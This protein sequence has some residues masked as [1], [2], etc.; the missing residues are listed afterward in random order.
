MESTIQNIKDLENEIGRLKAIA[1]AQQSEL[2]YR[3]NSPAA[4]VQ[5]IYSLFT[6][7]RKEKRAPSSDLLYQDPFTTVSKE[8]IPKLLTATFFRRSNFVI[9]AMV[10]LIAGKAAGFLKSRHLDELMVWSESKL[11]GSRQK[12][13]D[14][15]TFGSHEFNSRK[16]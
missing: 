13:P 7:K 1:D 15:I 2:R 16:P 3:V 11:S 4:L 12:S 5:A 6:A 14:I 10:R 8:L 9:K